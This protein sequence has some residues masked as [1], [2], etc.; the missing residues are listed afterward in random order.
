[1]PYYVVERLGAI[2]AVQGLM[3]HV[4]DL[5]QHEM[6]TGM[7]C[8]GVYRVG[9]TPGRSRNGASE[10]TPDTRQRPLMAASFRI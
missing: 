7:I 8:T 3:S 5:S 4:R 6:N 2:L 10:R 1:M 9:M